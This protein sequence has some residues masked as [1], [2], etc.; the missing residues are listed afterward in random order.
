MIPRAG[1]HHPSEQLLST[2]HRRQL[3][4]VTGAT[5]AE[6]SALSLGIDHGVPLGYGIPVLISLGVDYAHAAE[7]GSGALNE[8]SFPVLLSNNA[9]VDFGT[10]WFHPTIVVGGSLH[11][12]TQGGTTT[13]GV[14]PDAATGLEVGRGMASMRVR[15]RHNLRVAQRAELAVRFGL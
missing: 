1:N 2:R 6:R 5:E 7:R 8:L 13:A 14:R 10:V 12:T 11:R 4:D 15:L 3:G 9:T